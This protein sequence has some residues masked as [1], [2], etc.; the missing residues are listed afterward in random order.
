MFVSGVS[1]AHHLA[2]DETLSVCVCDCQSLCLCVHTLVRVPRVACLHYNGPE[3]HQNPN[4]EVYRNKCGQICF[5]LWLEMTP[6]QKWVQGFRDNT[7]TSHKIE[8]Q[9]HLIWATSSQGQET[10]FHTFS[11]AMDGFATLALRDL[12]SINMALC[13]YTCFYMFG[14]SIEEPQVCCL[15]F[16]PC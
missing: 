15:G 9:R 14:R 10:I 7:E 12:R 16:K 5:D 1:Q 2:I 4:R 3:V 13:V 8:P 11:C 6:N